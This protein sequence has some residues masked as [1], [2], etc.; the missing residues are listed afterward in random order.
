MT[1]QT[2]SPALGTARLGRP[3]SGIFRRLV[4]R[5]A[6]ATVL[7]GIYSLGAV[8]VAVGVSGLTLTA[9]GISSTPARAQGRRRRGR[10]GG[11]RR[12]GDRWRGDRRCWEILTP[13]GWVC[14]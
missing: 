13:L 3:Q 12:R 1:T 9:A 11:R 14:L 4:A 5:F 8:G 2:L 7:L 6:A 10:R